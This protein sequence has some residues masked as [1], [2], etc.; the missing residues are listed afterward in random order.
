[1]MLLSITSVFVFIILIISITLF[2]NQDPVLNKIGTAGVS[3]GF[4]FFTILIGYFITKSFGPF[5]TSISFIFIVGV[6]LLILLNTNFVIDVKNEGFIGDALIP[7]DGPDSQYKLM[8]AENTDLDD[9][10][11]CQRLK[12]D[13]F[14]RKQE[15]CKS[16]LDKMKK[17]IQDRQECIPGDG[18][19]GPCDTDTVNFYQ[20]IPGSTVCLSTDMVKTDE[21]KEK[22]EKDKKIEE[23]RI[24]DISDNQR[25]GMINRCYAKDID[26]NKLCQEWYND[27]NYQMTDL[28]PCPTDAKK[29]MP[30]CGK[31]TP[32][33]VKTGGYEFDKSGCPVMNEKHTKCLNILK[34]Q[35]FNYWC[36]QKY[37]WEFGSKKIHPPGDESCCPPNHSR[38]SCDTYYNT[39]NPI[40]YPY[41]TDCHTPSSKVIWNIRCKTKYPNHSGFK[42]L[43]LNGINCP[44][45]TIRAKCGLENI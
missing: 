42:A 4:V 12:E 43:D 20:K 10:L 16:E 28:I 44:A 21:E 40:D 14:K 2:M 22:E 29:K 23:D 31:M 26:W 30:I 9:Q 25:Q 36:G 37:G 17:D 45:G 6:I 8:N 19:L 38:S 13:E 35:D 34:D 1:M 7:P 24:P 39:E 11:E 27:R 32:D 15:Q 33:I 5:I 41:M 18:S 3:I